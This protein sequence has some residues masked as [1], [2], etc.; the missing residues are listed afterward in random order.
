MLEIFDEPTKDGLYVAYVNPDW[1]VPY[2]KRKLLMYLD[3]KWSYPLSDQNYR[4]T[5]YG[6]I[7]PLPALRFEDE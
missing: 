5:I 4:D 7:G 6:C 3:G 2:A 1:K